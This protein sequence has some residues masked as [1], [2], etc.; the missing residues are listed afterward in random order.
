[1]ARVYVA[2]HGETTWN[3]AGRYQGRRESALTALGVRQGFALA[4]AF[5][6]IE[7]RIQR[8]IASPL[9]R[10]SATAKFV[11]DRLNIPL[12]ADD[13]LLE[14]AHGTWEGRLRDEIAANDIERFNLWKERP[15]GVGFEN[16]ETLAD[17]SLRWQSFIERFDASVPT[18]VVTH[19]AVV[20]VA[21]LAARQCALDQLWNVHVENAA[22]AEFEV[23]D[24]RWQ[25]VMENVDT[26]LAGLHAATGSQ[27][28]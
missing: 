7:P 25:L 13:R 6:R 20:R 19:D 4:D 18:L 2:R 22:F 27:A 11:T 21:I 16:G 24:G 1:M 3:L 17:V 9:L 5:E 8:I 10:C 23:A 12:D 28:L 14:I 26:H 15:G